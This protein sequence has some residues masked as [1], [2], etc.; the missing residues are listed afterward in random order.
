MVHFFLIYP[1]AFAEL[2]TK[3][4]II[5][6]GTPFQNNFEEL[7]TIMRLLLPA[8]DEAMYFFNPLTLDNVTYRRVD[9]IRK[10]LDQLVHIHNGGIFLINPLKD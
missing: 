7:R 3:K 2:R 8:N 5:L 9:E 6:S 1:K 4:L 10:K